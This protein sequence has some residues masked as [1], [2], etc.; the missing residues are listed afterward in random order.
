MHGTDPQALHLAYG[1][2]ELASVIL[3]LLQA[4]QNRDMD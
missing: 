1:T 4:T 3:E 2:I